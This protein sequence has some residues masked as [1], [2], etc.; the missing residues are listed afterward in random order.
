MHFSFRAAWLT[1]CL[2]RTTNT[3]KSS[4]TPRSRS[5]STCRHP[6][7]RSQGQGR[8]RSGTRGQPRGRRRRPCWPQPRCPSSRTTWT[9][10]GPRTRIRSITSGSEA[11]A[12]PTRRRRLPL[13][14]STTSR[15]SIKSSAFR[16]R[17]RRVPM[18]IRCQQCSSSSSSAV[19][20]QPCRSRSQ[21]PAS[22]FP[23]PLVRALHRYVLTRAPINH[24]SNKRI[25]ETFGRFFSCRRLLQFY[26]WQRSKVV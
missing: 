16:L 19:R 8:R 25:W 4:T 6:Q 11:A 23:R 20:C 10:R 2:R 17:L 3:R 7:R 13:T 26:S 18:C 21:W 5:P 14:D 1:H 24:Y 9:W 15:N 12:G 22:P